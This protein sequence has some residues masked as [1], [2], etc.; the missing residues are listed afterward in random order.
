MHPTLSTALERYLMIERST[1]TTRTYR[2]FLTRFVAS[3]GPDRPLALISRAD[4][5]AF[6]DQMKER[7]VKYADHPQR[8]AVNAPLSPRTVF[9]N[10]Q[11][12][13]SFFRWC[14]QE[15]LLA[16]SPADF[17]SAR[18]PKRPLGQG[19]AATDDELDSMLTAA[20][21]KPRDYA[22]V[23]LLSISGCR[24]N[25]AATLRIPDL[26]LAGCSAFVEGKGSIA[27]RVFFDAETAA[28]L[29]A[30]LSCRPRVSHD[31]VF[32]STRGHGPLTSQG[33]SLVVRRLSR[34]TGDRSL[35]SHSLRHRVGLKFARERVAPRVAQH[36]LGHT[37]ISTTLEYYQDVDE[38]DL[39]SAG[40]LL[41]VRGN[42]WS[43][44]Q[45]TAVKR[46]IL[47]PAVSLRDK[48][49]SN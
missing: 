48:T 14:L 22:L 18:R 23:M 19:K 39:R 1:N 40:A 6:V 5:R 49:G 13:R 25:E 21:Y 20:R 31:F 27:R 24:A 26:D 28:A 35:G 38:S 8:P 4:V 41:S 32:I 46:R 9:K 47:R 43:N 34:L 12:I 16:E 44:K 2:T 15:N 29:R 42:A 45:K 36:Y 11:M 3:I 10:C 37:N 17:L 30:W 7:R 33:V